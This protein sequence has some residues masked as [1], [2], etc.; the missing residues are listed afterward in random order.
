MKKI[1]L[2]F[3]T[4]LCISCI[5]YAEQ[6]PVPTSNGRYCI[7]FSPHLQ[8]STF[9]LDTR[10]GKTWSL[11]V[12]ENEHYCWQ[13]VEYEWFKSDGTYGGFSRNAIPSK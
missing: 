7:V 10:T 12:D 5:A 3:L 1:I 8:R 6:T 11:A 4:V 2:M 9:L 13:Q